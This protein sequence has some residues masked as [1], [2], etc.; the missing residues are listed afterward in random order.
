VRTWRRNPHPLATLPLLSLPQWRRNC[1][2]Y[3]SESETLAKPSSPW[4]L[5]GSQKAW[6]YVISCTFE[7]W[8]FFL[9]P[10]WLPAPLDGAHLL[11]TEQ[12]ICLV[13]V[14]SRQTQKQGSELKKFVWEVNTRSISRR[15]RKRGREGKRVTK[16]GC[17]IK[18]VIPEDSGAQSHWRLLEEGGNYISKRNPLPSWSMLLH[19]TYTPLPIIC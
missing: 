12:V 13:L 10:A 7:Y 1:K 4:R 18:K 5:T 9:H 8:F 15:G 17:D 3:W 14:S 2:F 11:G 19:C 16:D 6:C